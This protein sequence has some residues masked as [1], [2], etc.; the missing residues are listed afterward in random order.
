MEVLV[1]IMVHM[2]MICRKLVVQIFVRFSLENVVESFT[3][4]K[5]HALSRLE[6]A[7]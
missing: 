3:K 7:A 4:E 2:K 5:V 1:E 6:G